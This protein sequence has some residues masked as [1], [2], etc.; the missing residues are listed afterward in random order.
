MTPGRLNVLRVG[1]TRVL[2]DYAHNAAAISGLMQLV[3][4]MPADKRIGVIAA[5]GDRRD[6]DLREL[7]RLCGNLDY[8]VVKEDHDRRGRAPGESAELICQ[9]LRDSGIGSDQLEVVLLEK[10]AIQRALE[11]ADDD[12][13]VVVLAEKVGEVLS[14]I[15]RLAFQSD[16]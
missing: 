4:A 12:D 5:P 6:I 9:G 16:K 7:G 8:V 2:I 14:H 1:R 13:V 10:A 3:F 11:V 15:E